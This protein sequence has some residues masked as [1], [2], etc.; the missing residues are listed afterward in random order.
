MMRAMNSGP[1]AIRTRCL[2]S[3]P[4]SMSQYVTVGIVQIMPISPSP[5]CRA[6]NLQPSGSS[7][8]IIAITLGT[9]LWSFTV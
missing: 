7:T 8:P 5:F 3:I 2:Y 1:R 6:E 9:S 4:S